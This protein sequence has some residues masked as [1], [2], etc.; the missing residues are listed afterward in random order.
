MTPTASPVR[1]RL[2]GPDLVMVTLLSGAAGTIAFDL[3]GQAI[4]PLLGLGN[5]APVGLARSL[6]GNL[7]LPN[8]NPAGTLMHLFLVGLVAYPLGWILIARPVLSRIVPSLGWFLGSLL[9]GVGL[10]VFAIGLVTMVAGLPFFL[11]FTRITW[12]A[13]AGHVLYAIAQVAALEWMSR[14]R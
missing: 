2:S 7:G 14:R 3:W 5:L 1:P 6:L 11:D 12:V 10:W 9:Y 4:S 8:G 13:L